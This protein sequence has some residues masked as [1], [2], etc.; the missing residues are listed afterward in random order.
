MC[1][2]NRASVTGFSGNKVIRTPNLDRLAQSGVVFDNAYTP[3]PICI[4][5]RQC[6]MTGQYSKACGCNVYGDDLTPGYM[7]FSRWFSRYAYAT[8]ACGKLHHYGQD[9]MQGWTRRIGMEPEV[10]PR[11]IEGKDALSFKECFVSTSDVKWTQ[12]KEVKR[13]S[14][15]WGPVRDQDDYTV[16]GAIRYIQRHFNDAWYDR[17]QRKAP[18]LLKVSL[19]KPHY[20]YLAD[21]ELFQYYLNRVEPFIEEITFDHPAMTPHRIKAGVDASEREIRRATAAYYAMVEESDRQ[22][23]RVMKALEDVGENLDDWIIIY[24]TDHGEMQG[25]HGVWEK[26]KFYEGSAKVPL[27]IRW[28][29]CFGH[30]IVHENVNLC[31]LFATMCEMAELPVPDGL[32]SRSLVPL[33]EGKN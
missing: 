4:P 29:K 19:L 16:D 2:E 30:R 27:V 14:I 12:V 21:E 10:S 3:S 11:F 22:F 18:L 25:E 8:V 7:T 17:E 13:A 6:M 20:P 1:D 5:A 26:Q 9:Q 33:M 28:P 31:D 32:E 24:T 23:G 15:G